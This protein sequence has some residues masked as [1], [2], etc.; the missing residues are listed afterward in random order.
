MKA[1][2]LLILG[3]MLGPPKPGTGLVP[4]IKRVTKYVSKTIDVEL[5][6]VLHEVTPGG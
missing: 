2:L 6:P 5:P 3:L 4:P 1:V